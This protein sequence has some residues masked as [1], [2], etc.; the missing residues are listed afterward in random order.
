MASST[1]S[2]PDRSRTA[3]T[4]SSLLE[5]DHR[6][7]ALLGRRLEARAAP[8]DDDP[9]RAQRLREPYRDQADGPGTDD[10]DRSAGR[11]AR[12]LHPV[13]GHAGGIDQGPFPERDSLRQVVDAADRIDVV[14]GVGA[15]RDEA[16]M[17]VPGLGPPVVLAEVVATLQAVAAVAAALVR[18]ARHPVA[19]RETENAV[20]DVDDLAGPFV[21]G[22]ERIRRRPGPGQAAADDLGIAAA[23]RDTA[24]PAQDLVRTRVRDGHLPDLEGSGGSQDKRV[25]HMFVPSS[26]AN[27]SRSSLPSNLSASAILTS[28]ST[29]SPSS[30]AVTARITS[31]SL[32]LAV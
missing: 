9:R 18:F 26:A 16:V 7:G 14:L 6:V 8:D 4:G 22:G 5:V 31:L 21:P 10:D 17:A 11:D 30:G 12:Q 27:R 13:Q 15:L 28:I 1:P 23:N 24:D 2:P 32:F 19:G 3:L 20:A 29:S 25:H